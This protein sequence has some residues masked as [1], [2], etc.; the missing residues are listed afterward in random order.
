M[1]FYVKKPTTLFVPDASVGW[2]YTYYT[3]SGWSETFA[4]RQQYST[5]TT[6]NNLCA[7]TADFDSQFFGA[8][9]GED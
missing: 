4:D 6:P 8:T 2:K 3:G 1:A 5:N 7:D 9:V